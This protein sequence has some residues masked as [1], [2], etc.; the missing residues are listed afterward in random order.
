MSGRLVIPIH[1]ERGELVAY[2]G[3][4]IDGSEPR[5]KLP[6]GFR[7]SQVLFSLHR[8]TGPD[9]IVVEGFFDCMKVWQAGHQ[10]VVSLMGSKGSLYIR[11][12]TTTSSQGM[13]P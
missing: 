6:A 11:S 4:S 3:R 10:A 5:Y 13:R 1:N 9:V 12:T 8:V 2:A 7:K